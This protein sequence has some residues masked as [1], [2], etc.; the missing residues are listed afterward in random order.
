[1][2]KAFRK[3][4]KIIIWTVIISF[5]LWGGF[6]GVTQFQSPGSN[7]GKIFGKNISFQEFNSFY[8]ATQ[9]F[10]Y[11]EA[12]ATDPDLIRLQTWQNVIL[13]YEAVVVDFIWAADSSSR[14][15]ASISCISATR[16]AQRRDGLGPEG[17]E[18][19]ET[20]SASTRR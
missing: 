10:S 3:N 18:A 12:P 5:G 9:I 20:S 4:T 16:D 14:Q 6:A 8:R 17:N 2:L 11:S 13:S 7:A 19:V 1:M 15:Y